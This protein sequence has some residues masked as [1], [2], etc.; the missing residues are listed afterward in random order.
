MATTNQISN[1]SRRTTDIVMIEEILCIEAFYGGSL[2]PAVDFNQLMMI[3]I[4]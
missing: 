3:I 4:T 2:Y 1:I